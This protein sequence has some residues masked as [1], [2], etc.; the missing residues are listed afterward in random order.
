MRAARNF[1]DEAPKNRL[2]VICLLLVNLLSFG[3]G[4]QVTE[5]LLPVPALPSGPEAPAVPGQSTYP[6][7]TVTQ[8]PRPEFQ[9]VGLRVGDFFWFPRGELDESYKQYLC[10]PHSDIRF[11]HRAPA[12]LRPGIELSAERL[13]PARRLHVAILR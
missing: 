12:E 6:G 2:A 7:Q 13:E 5:P 9:P 11:D 4:A 1:C 10:D 8:R 3:A